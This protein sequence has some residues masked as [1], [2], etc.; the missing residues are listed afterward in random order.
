MAANASYTFAF[1]PGNL[2]LSTSYVWRDEQFSDVFE[3][4]ESKVPSYDTIGLRAI[5]TDA[6]DRYTI[7]LY[8]TNLT[9][10]EAPDN[11]STTRVAT[12]LATAAA[13]SAAGAQYYGG[14]NL[15]PPREYGLEVQYRFGN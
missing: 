1:S 3:T 7:M 8:G 14:L 11:A 5:W 10:E 12:G 6:R 15:S 4:E 2:I 9:D 13:P